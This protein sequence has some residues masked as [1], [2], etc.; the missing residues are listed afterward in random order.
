MIEGRPVLSDLPVA[1]IGPRHVALR[2]CLALRLRL[3][4]VIESTCQHARNSA[5]PPMPRRLAFLACLHAGGRSRAG[6]NWCRAEIRL[7]R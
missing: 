7:R 6:R 5:A 3:P 2:H 4:F 1:R